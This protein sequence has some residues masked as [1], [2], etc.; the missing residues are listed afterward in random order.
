[1]LK[2]SDV[3]YFGLGVLTFLT[4]GGGAGAGGGATIGSGAGATIG[5]T[6]G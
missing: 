5:A 6:T 2:S 1:M 3:K 4:F